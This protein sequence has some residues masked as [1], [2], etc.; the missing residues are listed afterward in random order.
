MTYSILKPILIYF[1]SAIQRNR[2]AKGLCAGNAQR[3]SNV[4]NDEL[5]P[6]FEIVAKVRFGPEAD[7]MFSC[8]VLLWL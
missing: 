3:R 4:R 8:L 1:R 2:W 5:R 6:V 7:V